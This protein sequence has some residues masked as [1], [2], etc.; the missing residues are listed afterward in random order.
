MTRRLA[1]PKWPDLADSRLL[2]VLPL[3]SCEQHG[4]HLPVDADHAVAEGVAQRAAALL[5]DDSGLL[6]APSQQHGA[7]GEHQGFPGTVSIRHRALYLLIVEPGRSV[8]C[9]ADR[10][11]VVNGRG[12]NLPRLPAAIATLRREGRDA[13]WWPCLPRG[14]DL[15]AGRAETSM[16]LRLRGE[17]VRGER[18]VAGPCEPLGVLAGPADDR[19]RPRSQPIRCARRAGPGKRTAVRIAVNRDGDAARED[20]RVWRVGEHGRLSWPPLAQRGGRT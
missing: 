2:V 8:L 20:I 15:H 5:A 4:P 7:S 10:L 16:M 6:V 13:G 3:G 1:D 14:A 9:W 12:G 11:L 17:A 19:V 18:A